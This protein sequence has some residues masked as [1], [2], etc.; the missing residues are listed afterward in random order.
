MTATLAFAFVLAAASTTPCP[1]GDVPDG[2]VGA[3]TQGRARLSLRIDDDDVGHMRAR[4]RWRN[5][6]H[7]AA[8]GDATL[9]SR[10]SVLV[11]TGARVRHDGLAAHA[12]LADADDAEGAWS[13]F[14]DALTSGVAD[15]EVRSGRV[16]VAAV[17]EHADDG[18]VVRAAGAC[19]A[20]TI[21]VDIDALLTAV[22]HDG[23]LRFFVPRVFAASAVDVDG[24]GAVWI[25]GRPGRHASVSDDLDGNVDGDVDDL[26]AF[27]VDV[28]RA[29][30]AG[31]GPRVHG[32]LVT[33]QPVASSSSSSSGSSSSS[34]DATAPHSATAASFSL[35]H[36]A[37]DLPRPLLDAPD[38]LRVVFVVDA[39]VSAGDVGVTRALHL[40]DAVLDE[41]PA[42]AG[43]ALLTAARRPTLVVPPW[44]GV[45]ERHWPAVPV[46]NG[47]NVADAVAF[48]HRIATDALP[49]RGRVIVLSDLQQRGTD[50]RLAGAIHPTTTSPS[51]SSSP[52]VHVVALPADMDEGTSVSFTRS[53]ADDDENRGEV[54]A[55]ETTGGVFVRVDTQGSS[56]P[57][58]LARYLVR[59]T[60]LD[61]P[62]LVVDGIVDAPPS[63][64]DD[65]AR[66]WLSFVPD[67]AGDAG[68]A[69]VRDDFGAAEHGAL[70]AFVDEGGGLRA[71]WRLDHPAHHATLRGSL[72]GTRIEVPLSSSG[73]W[74]TASTAAAIA[75]L[76]ETLADDDVRAA[77][78]RRGFVSRVTSLL[79]LPAWRPAVPAGLGVMSSSC[80][81]CCNGDHFASGGDRGWG[82]DNAPPLPRL[83]EQEVLDRL[84]SEAA[85]RCDSAVDV[86]IEV[87]DLEVLDVVARAGG[88]CVEEFFWAQRLD[89]QDTG[90]ASFERQGVRTTRAERP[91]HAARDDAP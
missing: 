79:S 64:D 45:R 77:A 85:R 35:V 12:T 71:S 67:D 57:R 58:A 90:D 81:C 54:V 48:A 47:S 22:P 7:G 55:V 89:R 14:I 34:T 28:F 63:D 42:D 41:L 27:V 68:D 24:E 30:R 40:V 50:H 26:G 4:L 88:A 33:L 3:W 13:T 51:P 44:R 56:D 60:R 91:A 80:G 17:V 61:D 37:L 52:L 65:G 39:S 87:G 46:Q 1:S 82:I 70:P 25:D 43:W 31:G 8:S 19:S 23:G 53:G 5:E 66:A 36:A 38:A 73:A 86:D 16:R 62:Q 18:A 32:G 21:D 2:S 59:P 10:G 84:A 69:G 29:E 6:T 74:P 78:R 20:R 11:V 72:W 83:V 49:G 76:D 15:D 9:P 75:A